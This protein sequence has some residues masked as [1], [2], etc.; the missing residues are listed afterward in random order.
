MNIRPLIIAALC[1]SL[2]ACSTDEKTPQQSASQVTEQTTSAT[3]PPPDNNG[4][5]MNDLEYEI[6]KGDYSDSK[7]KQCGYYCDVV[8]GKY[9]YTICSGECHT[10]GYDIN[11]TGLDVTDSGTVIVT[12]KQSSPAPEMMVTEA[13][14]YPNCIITFS[15]EPSDGII[16]QSPSGKEFERLGDD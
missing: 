5:M 16:I 12:V 13:F 10:G 1:L 4:T 2:T 8:G 14:T 6:S 7:Y 11:I 3:L 15:H 9:R